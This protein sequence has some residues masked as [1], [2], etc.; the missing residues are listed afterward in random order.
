[1]KARW[2]DDRGA[3]AVEMAMVAV[4]L[5]TVALGVVELSNATYVRIGL[6]EAAQDA[7][8][9]ASY[10]P[11]DP[12]GA[13]ARGIEASSR[14]DLLPGELS[15]SCPA[16]RVRVTINHTHDYITDFLD[17]IL[18]PSVVMTTE[19]TGEIFSDQACVPS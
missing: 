15:V 6:E 12:G 10:N 3:A 19:L 1:M 18:G 14:S 7:M 5:V 17:P 8:V 13:E 9:Y 2:T 11:G 4:F 16:D